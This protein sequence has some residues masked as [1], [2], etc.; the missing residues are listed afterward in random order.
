VSRIISLITLKTGCHTAH[1]LIAQPA[2]TLCS[3]LIE[4]P[5]LF[6]A[7]PRA[8]LAGDISDGEVV[9]SYVLANRTVVFDV[10]E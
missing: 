8:C 4:D 5:P 3:L 1:Y 7:C 6:A 10:E 9:T 2:C